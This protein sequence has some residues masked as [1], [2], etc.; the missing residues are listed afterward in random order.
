MNVENLLKVFYAI[1]A[2]CVILLVFFGIELEEHAYFGF[3]VIIFSM[4]VTHLVI[5]LRF[6]VNGGVYYGATISAFAVYRLGYISGVNAIASAIIIELLILAAILLPIIYNS[7]K[8]QRDGDTFISTFT[9]DISARFSST[10]NPIVRVI[11]NDLR[12]VYYFFSMRKQTPQSEITSYKET[13][14]LS[15]VIV[16][17]FL[18]FVESI[19]FHFFLMQKS[20][21]IAYASLV[22]NIYTIIYLVGDYN[23]VR[24]N[25][26]T[27]EGG[28]FTYRVGIRYSASISIDLIQAVQRVQEDEA[29][30]KLDNY[31][32]SSPAGNTNLVI[33][34]D[35]TI[36]TTGLIRD[37]NVNIIGVRIDKRD[38]FINILRNLNSDIKI[39]ESKEELPNFIRVRA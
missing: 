39:I 30:R 18:V 3:L 29:F 19:P 7:F 8:K 11:R 26:P 6:K 9:R 10:D 27:L 22:I 36:K 23:S 35:S 12:L 1:A 37:K 16:I 5:R 33:F 21:I 14:F 13:S 20:A 31:S 4:L 28:I 24:L 38:E 15:G 25:P 34:L 32:S 17:S 2:T